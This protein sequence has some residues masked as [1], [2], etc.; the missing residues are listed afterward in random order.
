MSK[1]PCSPC[2]DQTGLRVAPKP[3]TTIKSTKTIYTT[4]GGAA[5]R[6]VSGGGIGGPTKT[7]VVVVKEK[8][9]GLSNEAIAGIVGSVLGLVATIIGCIY[10]KNRR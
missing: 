2:Q 8:K 7:V 9:D 5:T 3:T 4:A 10:A 1:V 6:V